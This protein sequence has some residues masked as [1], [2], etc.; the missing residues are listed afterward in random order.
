MP[1]VKRQLLMPLDPS[2]W[3]PSQSE[4]NRQVIFLTSDKGDS[5]VPQDMQ[6]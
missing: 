3:M 4:R 1:V 6:H 2:H 5:V